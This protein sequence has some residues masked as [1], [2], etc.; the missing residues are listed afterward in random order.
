MRQIIVTC[1]EMTEID[2]IPTVIIGF[3]QSSMQLSFSRD[4]TV[5]KDRFPD[6]D[7]IGCSSE[8]NIYDS[9]PHVFLK[10]NDLCVFVCLDIKK[11]SYRIE[12]HTPKSIVKKR[13][14]Q[15]AAYS[16]L[17]FCS[18]YFL[19]LEEVIRDIRQSHQK[20]VGYFFLAEYL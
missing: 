17:I 2:F 10:D 3:Y 15:D 9:I 5:L 14:T 13:E 18:H 8:S 11:E 4:C 19:N 20:S 16:A 6:V 12:L 7:I 1:K